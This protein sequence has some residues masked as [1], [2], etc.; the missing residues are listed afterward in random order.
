MLCLSTFA[1]ADAAEKQFK[2]NCESEES[3]KLIGE[4]GSC[5]ILMTP[6]E[7]EER[8]GICSGTLG[9]LP[10]DVQYIVA[11][12]EAMMLLTCGL[13]MKNPTLNHEMQ[14][15]ASAYSV[16]TVLKTSEGRNIIKHDKKQYETIDG[17]VVTINFETI[18]ENSVAATSAS[19]VVRLKSG[20][21]SFKNVVCK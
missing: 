11:K 18:A 4:K 16:T 12:D 8:Q 9:S 1:M 5:R 10:C 3:R 14:A 2:Q 13:D 17:N 19:V 21:V 20:L 7:V 15:E 6:K